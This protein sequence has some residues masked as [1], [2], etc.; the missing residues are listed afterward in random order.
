MAL[1]NI[2]V[3]T[4]ADLTQGPSIDSKTITLW[5]QLSFSLGYYNPGG[6]AAGV[7]TLAGKETIDTKFFLQANINGELT[8]SAGQS[9]LPAVGGFQYHYVPTT[10]SIQ[11][12]YNGTELTA[13]ETV[14]SGVIN[15][16]VVGSFQYQRL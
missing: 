1:S 12:F 2:S 16:V 10:D 9:S 15:D 4:L 14:P 3:V 7:A 6:L 13:S 8:V 11:I 5:L